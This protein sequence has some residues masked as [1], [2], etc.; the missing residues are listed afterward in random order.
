MTT[1]AEVIDQIERYAAW[2]E[3]RLGPVQMPE[4]GPTVLSLSTASPVRRRSLG[5]VVAAAA[6]V[7]VIAGAVAVAMRNPSASGR[8]AP[9]RQPACGGPKSTSWTA[10]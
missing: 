1:D 9:R 10:D 5:V 4:T 8:S 2:L 7:L 6:V 3:G